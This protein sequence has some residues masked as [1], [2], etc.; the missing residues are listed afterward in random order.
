[1]I[2]ARE[3]GDRVV[4]VPEVEIDEAIV[5]AATA[6]RVS[7]VTTGDRIV[8][9]LAIDKVIAG[10]AEDRVARVARLVRRRRLIP[11]DRVVA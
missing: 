3:V 7:A 8:P 11:V 4:G 1:M 10:A 5:P 2:A 6:Q 9:A